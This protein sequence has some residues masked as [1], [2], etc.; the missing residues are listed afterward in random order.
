MLG[1]RRG[2]PSRRICPHADVAQDLRADA[3]GACGSSWL[4]DQALRLRAA[5][6]RQQASMP[7]LVS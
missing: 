4:R 2:L 6:L 5:E 7:S 1:M 3:V